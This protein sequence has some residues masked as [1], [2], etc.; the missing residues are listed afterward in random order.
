MAAVDIL[1]GCLFLR[2]PCMVC[3]PW[4]SL[5]YVHAIVVHGSALLSILHVHHIDS[6]CV[7]DV[8]AKGFR[9]LRV[10]SACALPPN[11][12]SRQRWLRR[13]RR[14][15]RPRWHLQVSQGLSQ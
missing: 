4:L 3:M 12:C 10:L 8:V 7:P 9:L 2:G 14:Q 13:P 1:P 15:Q 6:V 11:C 5:L